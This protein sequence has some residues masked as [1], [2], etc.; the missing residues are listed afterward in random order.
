MNKITDISVRVATPEDLEVLFETCRTAY[1]ENFA[2]HWNPGG[3][4]WYL[5]KVY[6]FEGIKS[7]LQNPDI[8]YFLAFVE[9][10]PAGFMKLKL[11]SHF[12]GNPN[13]ALEIEKIYFRIAYQRLGLG[14]R[15]INDA[16]RFAV[17]E[18]KK[19]IWLG[20]IDTNLPAFAFYKKLGFHEV[21]KVHLDMPYFK[22]EL[23]GMWRMTKE[24]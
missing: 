3:L 5:E 16:C 22:D 1:S 19:I 17:R 12:D 18:K 20:V 7:D 6:S 21:D 13:P 24:L 10:K 4:E 11:N 23:R 9:G 2:S 14:E 8:R 15:M